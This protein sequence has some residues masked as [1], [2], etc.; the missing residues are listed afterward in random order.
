MT[1]RLALVAVVTLA[2]L[3]VVF[4]HVYWER[5]PQAT[6][7]LDTIFFEQTG[8]QINIGDPKTSLVELYGSYVLI[9]R[10]DGSI[11]MVPMQRIHAIDARAEPASPQK[12]SADKTDNK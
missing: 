2:A 7:H 9:K 8:L 4:A 6:L 1:Q 12:P 3:L 5:Q 10:R 11:T